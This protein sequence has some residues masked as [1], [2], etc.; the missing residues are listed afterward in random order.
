M[1]SQGF[2]GGGGGTI[3]EQG[4]R[5]NG[6]P[7][8]AARNRQR[9]MGS[10]GVQFGDG[11]ADRG[12][13]GNGDAGRTGDGNFSRFRFEQAP[14]HVQQEMLRRQRQQDATKRALADQIDEQR[15]RK[16]AA[17]QRERERERYENEKVE[18]QRRELADQYNR[19]KAKKAAVAP[20]GGEAV[21]AVAGMDPVARAPPLQHRRLGD[22]DAEQG[23][24]QPPA[25]TL[26][27]AAGRNLTEYEL[28][29]LRKG[30]APSLRTR[31]PR[32]AP[33]PPTV[34]FASPYA[35]PQQQEPPHAVHRGMLEE[36]KADVARLR[37]EVDTVRREGDALETEL[38]MRQVGGA[39]DRG[40]RREYG[41]TTMRPRILE[42][43]MAGVSELVPF[44]GAMG[45][46][47][48]AGA[49]T[50]LLSLPKSPISARKR[51]KKA[52]VRQGGLF[53]GPLKARVGFSS[54]PGIAT[55]LA[56]PPRADP[57]DST[58]R[59]IISH[60]L[61]HARP[62]RSLPAHDYT[63]CFPA[64]TALTI[65]SAIS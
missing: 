30:I 59:R 24:Q 14:V 33:S 65:S 49:D 27:E 6:E 39:G 36:R 37:D 34:S 13:A 51:K 53:G 38:R 56:S 3:A 7:D 57:F 43:S 19:E 42:Q 48:A 20:G 62:G 1:G 64:R 21:V 54:G 26:A 29:R 22:G 5:I 4:G 28:E 41:Q 50:G 8:A 18:R 12:G 35:S 44:A 17:K 46:G 23:P 25:G 55:S 2:I 60:V 9:Q 16:A 61:L 40:G 45:G 11:G 32:R 47:G 63:P 15:R 10:A 31:A 52:R 58:A